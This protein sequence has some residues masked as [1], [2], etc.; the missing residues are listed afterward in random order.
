MQKRII[1]WV[2][3]AL[4]AGIVAV[5]A[6]RLTRRPPSIVPDAVVVPPEKP[7]VAVATPDV[8]AAK[9]IPKQSVA[10]ELRKDIRE[11]RD[12]SGEE[13]KRIHEIR[14]EQQL[15]QGMSNPNGEITRLEIHSLA[16]LEEHAD[17]LPKWV[18]DHILEVISEQ[19]EEG[20]R[21]RIQARR[22]VLDALVESSVTDEEYLQVQEWFAQ[23]DEFDSQVELRDY[24]EEEF[25]NRFDPEYLRLQKVIAHAGET[26]RQ[27]RSWEAL[28]EVILKDNFGSFVL[29]PNDYE[30]AF[31]RDDDDDDDE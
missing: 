14:A 21:K 19:L 6:M 27:E 16:E 28:Q 4:C 5:W 13:V 26:I 22:V 25:Y 15:Q 8:S 18:L 1:F 7:D 17:E 9:N 30:K 23:M 31:G 29:L 12:E 10:Q 2:N 20:A 24:A 11:L 3:V